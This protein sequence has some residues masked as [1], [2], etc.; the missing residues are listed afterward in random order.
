MIDGA[1]VDSSSSCL[2]FTETPMFRMRSMSAVLRVVGGGLRDCCL[3]FLKSSRV[4]RNV[5]PAHWGCSLSLGSLVCGRNGLSE[6][7]FRVGFQGSPLRLLPNVPVK[8]ENWFLSPFPLLSTSPMGKSSDSSR[9]G[10]LGALPL[11]WYGCQPPRP[12]RLGYSGCRLILGL[13]LMRVGKEEN[14]IKVCH[15]Q[16]THVLETDV[17]DRMDDHV[18]DASH[19]GSLV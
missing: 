3:L 11:P 15:H 5:G 14:L 9:Y 17:C 6:P 4:L 8:P 10:A 7:I 18:C 1:S 13:E 19:C 12:P 2:A 16:L